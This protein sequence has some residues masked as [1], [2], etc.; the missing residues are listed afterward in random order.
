MRLRPHGASGE[1]VCSYEEAIN[2]YYSVGRVWER[3]ALI[4]ARLIAGSIDLG[5][6]LLAELEP[7]I[8]PTEHSQD[9]LANARAMRRR[10]EERADDAN[11]K[12]GAGGIRD[13]EFLVQYYQLNFGGRYRRL[14]CGRP[15]RPSA[16]PPGHRL[17]LL[18]R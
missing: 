3:Q 2:Y 10:I 11:V 1:L 17:P 13:V 12:G 6:A 8:Y 18:C 16:R 14:R 4:K 15:C 7:W 9:D 5:D